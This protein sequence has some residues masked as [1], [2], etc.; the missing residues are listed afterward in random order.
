MI[1]FAEKYFEKEKAYQSL[2]LFEFQQ[3]FSADNQ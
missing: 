3:M 1:I 2:S